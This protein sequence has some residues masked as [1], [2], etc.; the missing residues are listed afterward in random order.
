MPVLDWRDRSHTAR[1][2]GRCVTCGRFTI[3]LNDSGQHQHKVCAEAER[4][5]SQKG[6]A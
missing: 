6:G 4:A 3:L 2:S 5:Q 1:T